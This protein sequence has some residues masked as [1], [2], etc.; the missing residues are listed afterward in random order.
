MTTAPAVYPDTAGRSVFA[1]ADVCSEAGLTLP[2]AAARPVFDDDVW[3]FTHVAGL[4]VQM[5]LSVRRFDFTVIAGPAWRTLAKELIFA[6][7]CPRHAAVAPLPRA[8]RT[9]VHL[10]TAKGR[11]DE[12]ATWFT[13]L[14]G[15]GV[16]SLAQVDADCCREYLAHRRYILDGNGAVVGKRGPA[17]CRRAA[18]VAVDLVSYRELF[19]ADRVSPGLRPWAGASAS[20]V[21]EMP[22]GL[23]GNKT[24]PVPGSVLQPLLASALH[25][26]TTVGPHAAGLI[27]E[28]Q[29]AGRRWSGNA[30]GLAHTHQVPEQALAALLDEYERNG[31]PL[32]L[33]PSHHVENRFKSGWSPADLLAPLALDL[34]AR[35]AGAARFR[36]PWIPVLRDRIEA[37]LRVVGADKPFGL[38]AAPVGRA[39]GQGAIPWTVP[40]DHLEAVALVGIIRTAA[41]ITLAAVSGMRSS[42]LMELRAGCCRPPEDHGTGLVRYRLA[43]KVIKGQPLGGLDDEWVVIEPAYQAARLLEQ[44]LDQPEDGVPLLGRFAFDVRYAWF[45]RWVNSPAG[46]RHGLAAIPA[47]PVTLRALRRTLALELAYRPGG[48]LAAKVQLKH[49]AVATTEGYASRP[50]GAQAELLAEVNKHE[51]ERNLELVWAEF[52]N[53]QQGIM[54]AGPGAREL[55]EFFAHVDGKLAAGDPPGAPKIQASDRDVLNLLTKRA[56]VLHLGNSNY[57]WFT[58]PSRALCLKLAGDPAGDRPLLGMCDSARCPQATHHPCHRPVWAEHAENTQTFLGQ[59]GPAR[60]TEKARLQAEY[61]RATRVLARIDQ[62]MAAGEPA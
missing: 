29:E 56:G 37:T 13:W 34:L 55:T 21:A 40:L 1:G 6:L 61:H 51:A 57:C 17:L 58:D 7:L 28:V 60:K 49:V 31:R 3:D 19:S 33:L 10:R 48:V 44:L 32:P 50:G 8:F 45:R 27:A 24:P 43:G 15:K 12:L 39:D 36:R 54:P 35:Q 9:P 2:A 25:L 38:V 52:R 14:A 59:L 11:L 30:P 4:P 41:I 18:Q 26:V 42:E 5:R 62:A 22:S 47:D 23:A 46:E 53:Y 20:A 16:A